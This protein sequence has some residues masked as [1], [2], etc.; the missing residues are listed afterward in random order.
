MDEV[1]ADP[2]VEHLRMT[3]TVHHPVLGPLAVVRNAVRIVG[4]PDTVRTPSPDA[5]DHTHEVL[6]GLGYSPEEIERLRAQ[7]VI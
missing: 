7:A 6:T 1:F 2:Q 3:Q 4:G 5:G